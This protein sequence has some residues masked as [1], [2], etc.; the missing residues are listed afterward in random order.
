MTGASKAVFSSFVNKKDK[1]I[2][3]EKR[4]TSTEGRKQAR[5]RGKECTERPFATKEMNTCFE[6][7]TSEKRYVLFFYHV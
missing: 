7:S 1:H 2:K 3:P 5:K 6:E 4:Q